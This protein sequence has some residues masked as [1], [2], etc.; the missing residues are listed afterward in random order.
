MSGSAKIDCKIF[1]GNVPFDCNNIEFRECFK[2]V[3]G[4]VIADLIN[5]RGFGF[6]ELKSSYYRDLILNGI[7][8]FFIRNRKLR[9]SVYDNSSKNTIETSNF[10]KLEQISPNITRDD[11]QNEF[12]NFCKVGKCFIDT[13]RLTGEKLST[14][15]VE[16]FD[17]EVLHQLLSLGVLLMHDKSELVLKPFNNKSSNNTF[18]HKKKTSLTKEEYQ[19]I[20]NAGRNAGLIEGSRLHDN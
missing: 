14:G 7:T 6:V 2:N 5:M 11:I 18:K 16:I 13:N 8:N 19:E 4:Y 9:L 17:A 12:S 3:D 20:Y 15:L 1:V 10:I